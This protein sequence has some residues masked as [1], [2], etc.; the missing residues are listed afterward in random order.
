MFLGRWDDRGGDKT[1]TTCQPQRGDPE[2]TWRHGLHPCGTLQE[3]G[4][5]LG[6]K[7]L[8]IW[9]H[10]NPNNIWNGHAE[11]INVMLCWISML[12]SNPNSNGHSSRQD[13][14]RL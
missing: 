2:A 10:L 4:S 9:G 13:A 8:R 6:F 7:R 11:F 5:F 14:L 12:A 1:E 3:W